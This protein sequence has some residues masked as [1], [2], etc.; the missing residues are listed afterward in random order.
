VVLFYY[1]LSATFGAI[2]LLDFFT[3]LLKLVALLLLGLLVLGI[4]LY[5]ARHPARRPVETP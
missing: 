5:A 4:M 3:P 1:T 2:A